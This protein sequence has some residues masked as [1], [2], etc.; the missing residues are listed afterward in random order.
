ML[1]TIVATGHLCLL[2]TW[3]VASLMEELN[4]Y[5]IWI[6][7]LNSHMWLVAAMLDSS[8]LDSYVQLLFEISE[9]FLS[10]SNLIVALGKACD[11]SIVSLG[12]HPSIH[13]LHESNHSVAQVKS[14][15]SSSNPL[16]PYSPHWIQQQGPLGLPPRHF[17]FLRTSFC[18]SGH[19]VQ[20]TSVTW[21][22]AMASYLSSCFPF[23]PTPPFNLPSTWQP[24]PSNKIWTMP[25]SCLKSS[26]P[27]F[28]EKNLNFLQWNI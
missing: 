1:F 27:L 24:E 11:C 4:F 14:L 12:A 10:I 7:S 21:T 3:N 9:C 5:F 23:W 8:A 2:C 22:I 19:P 6:N 18:P 15:V 25:V 16:F 26:C 17:Q 13:H 20:A 28:L